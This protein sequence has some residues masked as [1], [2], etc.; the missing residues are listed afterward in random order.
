MDKEVVH[1]YNGRFSAIKS[2]TFEL[3][4]MRWVN[5]EPVIQSEVNQKEKDKY[6]T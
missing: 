6:R 2:N 1:I 3:V 5:V 4:I